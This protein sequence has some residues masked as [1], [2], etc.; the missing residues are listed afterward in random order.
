MIYFV[1]PWTYNLSTSSDK[2][3]TP[4]HQVVVL[5]YGIELWSITTITDLSIH[6]LGQIIRDYHGPIKTRCGIHKCWIQM[7]N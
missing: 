3:C 7:D 1:G 6:V 5:S 2:T 4:M